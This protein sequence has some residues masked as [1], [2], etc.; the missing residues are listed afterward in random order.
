MPKEPA[1]HIRIATPP[2]L[3]SREER[4]IAAQAAPGTNGPSAA[5]APFA[6]ALPPDALIEF[7]VQC[8]PGQWIDRAPLC[9]RHLRQ[10]ETAGHGNGWGA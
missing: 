9:L 2:G 6:T 4:K 3:G 10:R 1:I 5:V 8:Q 7:V